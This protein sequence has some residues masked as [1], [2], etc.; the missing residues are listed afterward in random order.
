MNNKFED[1]LGCPLDVIFKALK[2][3]TIRYKDWICEGISLYYNGAGNYC[4]ATSYQDKY[5]TTKYIDEIDV[6]SYGIDW[7]LVE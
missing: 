7:W 3:D 6:A 5:G 1:K 4:F 2:N